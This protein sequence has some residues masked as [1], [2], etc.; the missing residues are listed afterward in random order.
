MGKLTR[1]YGGTPSLSRGQGVSESETQNRP[2]TDVPI[3]QVDIDVPIDGGGAPDYPPSRHREHH[4]EGDKK[5]ENDQRDELGA[6]GAHGC[7]SFD[8]EGLSESREP[9]R[10]RACR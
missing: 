10:R 6:K 1:A 7:Q 3:L 9:P 4:E 5:Q 2:E 8:N